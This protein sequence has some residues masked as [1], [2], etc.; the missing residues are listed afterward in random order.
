[1]PVA[2]LRERIRNAIEKLIE[3]ALWNRQV[4]VQEVELKC[5]ADF[6]DTVKD[7]P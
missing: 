1:L 6:A 7:L 4:A 2:E 5:I 3:F